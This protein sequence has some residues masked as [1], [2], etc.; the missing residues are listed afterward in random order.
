MEASLVFPST[1]DNQSYIMRSC[2]KKAWGDMGLAWAARSWSWSW[3][4]KA[5]SRVTALTIASP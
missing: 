2:L 5:R 1:Q 4:A 3:K